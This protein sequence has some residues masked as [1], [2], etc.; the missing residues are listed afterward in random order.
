[1]A[2]KFKYMVTKFKYVPPKLKYVAQKFDPEFK[3]L[4]FCTTKNFPNE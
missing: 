3:Y 4:N 2:P 1:M